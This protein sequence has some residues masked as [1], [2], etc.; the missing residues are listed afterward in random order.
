[1]VSVVGVGAAVP[2]LGRAGSGGASRGAAERV[3][4]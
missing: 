3:P 1:M 4:V 2:R